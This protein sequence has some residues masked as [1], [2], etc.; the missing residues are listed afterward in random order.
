M[1]E[2]DL[3]IQVESKHTNILYAIMVYNSSSRS[4]FRSIVDYAIVTIAT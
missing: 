4:E 3:K 1:Y 2:F